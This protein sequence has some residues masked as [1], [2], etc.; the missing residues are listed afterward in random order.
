M[1]NREKKILILLPPKT[2][3]ISLESLFKVSI[4]GYDAYSRN[5]V[6]HAHMYL[7]E[8]IAHY[9]I[10]D[11]ENW[12]VFQTARNP[13]DKMVSAFYF[14]KQVMREGN[15]EF[16]KL[17]FTGFLEKVKEN[18]YLLP[19]NEPEFGKQFYFN[20]VHSE[21]ERKKTSGG[22]RFYVPQT[23]WIDVKAINV[24]YLKLEDCKTETFKKIGLPEDLQF[25]YKNKSV[26][27]VGSYKAFYNNTSKGI[28]ED[29][30]GEDLEKLQ[31]SYD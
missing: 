20:G 16:K 24:E 21:I 28:V 6:E 9:K 22:I 2:G 12:K 14:Q 8:A 17:T 26:K 19:H 30:Y 18:I 29:L 10:E 3:T 7:S 11:I 1:I 5:N 4:A 25:P 31:Y 13:F 15:Q 23:N 27:R